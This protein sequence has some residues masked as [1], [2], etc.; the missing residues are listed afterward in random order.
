M[1]TNI[2]SPILFSMLSAQ[3][4][5]EEG[6]TAHLIVSVNTLD[7]SITTSVKATKPIN[8][9]GMLEKMMPS[10]ARKDSNFTFSAIIE[11]INLTFGQG[12]LINIE[13]SPAIHIIDNLLHSHKESTRFSAGTYG[14]LPGDRSVA[15]DSQK[16][17]LKSGDMVKCIDSSEQ[18]DSDS[19][20]DL[21]NGEHYLIDE[22]HD[23]ESLLSPMVLL[24]GSNSGPV[25]P[26]RFVIVK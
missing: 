2:E 14:L 9:V 5:E 23:E 26:E 15:Y 4:K 16:N 17:E 13:V 11:A 25:F 7:M 1:Q 3:V 20:F 8:C 10:Y 21:V 22:I 18:G 24:K 12:N 19:D 6:T